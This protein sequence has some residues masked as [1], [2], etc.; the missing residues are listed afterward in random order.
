MARRRAHDLEQLLTQSEAICNRSE[1]L[2]GWAQNGH[3]MPPEETPSASQTPSAPAPAPA[4]GPSRPRR[5][6]KAAGPR[7]PTSTEVRHEAELAPAVT[8]FLCH[9]GLTVTQEL[10]LYPTRRSRR[11][12]VADLAAL[13]PDPVA[14]QRRMRFEG[15]RVTV[16]DFWPALLQT[17]RHAPTG[18]FRRQDLLGRLGAVPLTRSISAERLSRYLRTLRRYGYLRRVDRATYIKRGDYVPVATAGSL[19]AVELKRRSFRAALAQA[20]SY[21]KV[22]DRVWVA[23]AGRWQH[24]GKL[25]QAF[26]HWGIGA[27]EIRGDR[28]RQVL[29]P[30]PGKGRDPACAPYR[31]ILE[32]RLVR[33]QVLGRP[34][35]FG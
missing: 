6:P 20:R 35:A 3:R 24:E 27:L 9:R 23:T 29:A 1:A 10:C 34:R 30:Q 8:R 4:P 21:A 7:P 11:R 22:M 17:L 25:A 13:V 33:E 14:I 31:R 28:V 26:A 2:L 18:P 19:A 32:E 16:A 15:R 12:T 5:P